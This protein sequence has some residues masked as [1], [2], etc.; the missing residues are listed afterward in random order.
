MT[1]STLQTAT[2]L[3]L[4]ISKE[5]LHSKGT[6]VSIFTVLLFSTVSIL[7]I[8]NASIF[9]P[10]E[11]QNTYLLHTFAKTNIPYLQNDFMVVTAD[12]FAIFTFISTAFAEVFGSPGF[13]ILYFLVLTT[14]VGAVLWLTWHLTAK[15]DFALKWALITLPLIASLMF[16]SLPWVVR[17]AIQPSATVAGRFGTGAAGQYILGGYWQPSE[18]GTLLFVAAIAFILG[19]SRIAAALIALAIAFHS[20]YLIAGAMLMATICLYLAATGKIRESLI[21]GGLCFLL[22]LPTVA[23]LWHIFAPTSVELHERASA[24]LA[25]ERIPHHALPQVWFGRGELVRIL[26]VLG[27]IWAWRRN[28]RIVWCLTGVLSLILAATGIACWIDRDAVYL[29]FPW[30][31]AV[32]LGPLAIVLLAIYFSQLVVQFIGRTGKQKRFLERFLT[33]GCLALIVVMVALP[34]AVRASSRLVYLPEYYDQ[35]LKVLTNWVKGQRAEGT[36]YLTPPQLETF[37]LSTLQSVF[38]DNKSHPYR[39]VEIIEWQRRLD[40]AKR[41]YAG[42]SH[43]DSSLLAKFKKA[44]VTHILIEHGA[45]C[46]YGLN[47]L[48]RNA[49]YAILTF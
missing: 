34:I 17:N 15:N 21:S 38:V 28:A 10:Y 22:V 35:D 37:R 47:L 48:Y 16:P 11:N 33:A 32:F 13:F 9:F 40:L 25:R 7:Y 46:S 43:C 41:F 18:A 30:R 23:Y 14:M 44:G 1:K 8:V 5:L 29:L 24:I 6:Q 12:P 45:G 20:S 4:H 19:H 39:D 26:L 2:P 36:L 49:K 42:A 27:A 31:A 3:H